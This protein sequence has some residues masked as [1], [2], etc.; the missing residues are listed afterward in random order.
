MAVNGGHGHT[1]TLRY[2]HGVQ[3]DLVKLDSVAIQ[4]ETKSAWLGGGVRSGP[5]IRSL[6]DRGYV[7]TTGSCDCVG[8]LGAALGGGHGRHE[9]LYGMA[10]DNFLQLNVVLANAT[11]IL[12]S[13]T[14]HPDLF[15][16]MKGAG[17]N[18][19]IV[20]SFEMKLFPRGPD[21][22]HYHNYIWT[23][24][25]LDAVFT[26]LNNLHQKGK[27][28]V[29]MAANWGFY[30]MNTTISNT[31]PVIW[32]TFAYRGSAKDANVHLG[33]FTAIKSVYEESGDVPYPLVAKMQ[34][35]ADDD[36]VCQKGNIRIESTAGLQEYNLTAQ[37]Q[38]FAGFK[39]RIKALPELALTSLIL[40]EGYSTK[41]VMEK[42]PADS[43]YPFR[44]DYHLT[45]FN[46]IVPP[47]RRDL[48]D[49][50]HAWAREVRD[51]WNKGQPGRTPNSYVNYAS[52][53]ET[54]E[55]WYGHEPWRLEKLRGLKKVYDPLNR[56]GFYNPIV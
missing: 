5:V 41:A 34:G 42:N 54:K 29:N 25:K 1:K 32:W 38:L 50:A 10:S 45:L 16:A 17:H 51:T 7:T 44:D 31:D 43:A 6:W 35:T 15:W 56:F 37:H 2:F 53:W 49:E 40:Q 39:R 3:I 4:P 18:F 21:T 47:G 46:A 8:L 13:P 33:P 55:E 23:G 20:T 11:V 30:W 48:E 19:G 36:Y 52:G 9:G 12:V 27:T 28:P 24:D 26:A 22:W 14:S